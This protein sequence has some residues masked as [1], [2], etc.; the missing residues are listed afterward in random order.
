M[1]AT[2]CGAGLDLRTVLALVE[3]GI[4]GSAAKLWRPD[5][6]RERYS[7][8]LVEMHGVLRASV[9]LMRTAAVR[10]ADQRLGDYLAVHIEEELGH[11]DWL[12]TDMAAAGLDMDAERQKAPSAAVARLVGPQYYW[13]NHFDP[14]ALL[15]Y[16]AVLE[17]NAP[18]PRL[19]DLLAVRTGLPD[20]AFET[21]RHHA[22]VD[23]GHTDA[24][25]A[26]LD[27]L[28]PPPSWRQ[29]IRTS[30]LQ[31]ADALISLFDGLSGRGTRR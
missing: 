6:L 3:P 23:S 7:R 21:L 12:L 19:P 14:I 17:G 29:A 30:A 25:F 13:I 2:V 26:M 22:E 11:D 9:P 31:T 27:E 16:L 20:R 10:C 8:Y 24:V 28:D 5:G 18:S 15:G 1:T 4:R